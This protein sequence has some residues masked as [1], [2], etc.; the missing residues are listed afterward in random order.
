MTPEAIKSM[1]VA[2][3][4]G[5]K[6]EDWDDELFARFHDLDSALVFHG[7]F[8]LA[9][10]SQE[11][12]PAATAS[13]LLY[14]INPPCLI[15]CREAILALLPEWDVSIQEVVFYIAEQFG[16]PAVM[17]T[18]EELGREDVDPTERLGTVRYWVK[19][20]QEMLDERARN[21]AV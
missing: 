13:W 11:R 6:W 1:I 3:P 10:A 8:P 16:I 5:V 2:C 18:I 12:G 20:F 21:K 19:C 9:S 15:S 7:L 4:E 14:K 17:T